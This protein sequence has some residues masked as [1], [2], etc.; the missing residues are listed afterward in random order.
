T[1]EEI[2][3]EAAEEGGWEAWEQP[4]SHSWVLQAPASRPA[5]RPAQPASRPAPKPARPA[6]PAHIP[7]PIPAL[8]PVPAPNT[9]EI[10]EVRFLESILVSEGQE[11]VAIDNVMADR[12]AKAVF[13]TRNSVLTVSCWCNKSQHRREENTH[14]R[15]ALKRSGISKSISSRLT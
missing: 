13:K 4:K 3:D 8:I 7:T 11:H 10:C 12:E 1:S 5:T 6:R 2:V 15:H 9:V 14:V